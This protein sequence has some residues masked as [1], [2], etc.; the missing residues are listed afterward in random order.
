MTT[1]VGQRPY[2]RWCRTEHPT[3]QSWSQTQCAQARRAR[4]RS[5]L[6]GHGRRRRTPH[7]IVTSHDDRI[8]GRNSALDGGPETDASLRTGP[9]AK[10]VVAWMVDR[11]RCLRRNKRGECGACGTS[12]S[13]APSGAPCV[14]YC[15]IYGRRAVGRCAT[16]TP[17]RKRRLPSRSVSTSTPRALASSRG[18]SHVRHGL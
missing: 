4:A 7:W 1:S 18:T 9:M 6:E 5:S 10:A 8:S 2:I 15:R 3:T 12:W 16:L 11:R 17:E 14:R 13:K